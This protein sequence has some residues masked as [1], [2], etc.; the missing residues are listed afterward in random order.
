VLGGA[1]RRRDFIYLG[2]A[3]IA[4]MTLGTVR[5][6]AWKPTSVRKQVTVHAR[7]GEMFPPLALVHR[8]RDCEHIS[9]VVIANSLDNGMLAVRGRQVVYVGVR[10]SESAFRHRNKLERRGQET[11]LRRLGSEIETQFQCQIVQTTLD[12]NPGFRYPYL[13]N[14][15]GSLVFSRL[16]IEEY[17][18]DCVAAK[19]CNPL[20]FS[21][22]S[23]I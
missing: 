19:L 5:A 4:Y 3:N 20:P 1:T 14:T 23:R 8:V 2:C 7:I 13:G 9:P 12:P 11:V 17:V 6:V 10:M 21:L 15:T 18:E 22:V 16:V